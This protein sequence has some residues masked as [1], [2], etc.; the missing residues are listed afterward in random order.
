M[1]HSHK[2]K[3]CFEVHR[4]IKRL[5]H[6]LSMPENNIED[7]RKLVNDILTRNKTNPDYANEQPPNT[8]DRKYRT[9]EQ[10]SR[11]S[12][13]TV[14]SPSKG[15]ASVFGGD[16]RNSYRELRRYLMDIGV[17]TRIFSF[18]TIPLPVSVT[19]SSKSLAILAKDLGSL[20]NCFQFSLR[21]Q[22]ASGSCWMDPD[23]KPEKVNALIILFRVFF[24]GSQDSPNFWVQA[25]LNHHH[26]AI[27]SLNELYGSVIIPG[28]RGRNWSQPT[29]GREGT[30]VTYFEKRFTDVVDFKRDFNPLYRSYRAQGMR[31]NGLP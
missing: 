26:D 31:G 9:D 12:N 19:E 21:K 4:Y 24:E 25:V 16:P 11:R 8:S 2:F 13:A 30:R 10:N 15:D 6:C 29:L 7:I 22:I 5:A 18:G 3:P 14:V 28:F 23:A 20:D 27:L 17:D 1:L